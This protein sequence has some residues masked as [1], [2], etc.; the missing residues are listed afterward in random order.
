[1]KQKRTLSQIWREGVL[2]AA[3][4]CVAPAAAGTE[5]SS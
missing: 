4:N 3:H 2:T 1:M 5:S